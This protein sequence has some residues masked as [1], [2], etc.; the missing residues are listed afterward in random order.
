MRWLEQMSEFQFDVDYVRGSTHVVPDALSRRPDHRQ[1][2]AMGMS[3]VDAGLAD[4]IR[5]AQAECQDRAWT[6]LLERAR[7]PGSELQWI[8]GVLYRCSASQRTIVV[9]DVDGLREQIV[10]EHHDVPQGGHLGA[11]RVL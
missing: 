8:D 3:V 2:A 4:A 11:Y 5:R 10:Y 1:G 7:Q 6:S 9:P